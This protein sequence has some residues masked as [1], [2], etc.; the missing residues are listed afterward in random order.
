MAGLLL[1]LLPAVFANDATAVDAS[2]ASTAGIRRLQREAARWSGTSLPSP[3][4]LVRLCGT[5]M[6]C[7]A[8]TLAGFLGHGARLAYRRHPDTDTIRMVRSLPSI[9]HVERPAEG[10]LRV[11]F[12]RFGRAAL[13]E[14]ETVLAASRSPV[15]ILEMDLR[16]HHGGKLRDMMRLASRFTGP[17]H[18]ALALH[19]PDGRVRW[20]DLPPPPRGTSPVIPGLRIIVNHGTASSAEIFAALLRRYGRA[21]ILGNGR[22]RGKNWLLRSIAVTNDVVLL[23]PAEHV[24]VPGETLAGGLRPDGPFLASNGHRTEKTGGGR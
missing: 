21:R 22:T 8:R 19:Y 4:S 13:R 12:M 17:V 3:A 1:C 24:H 14:L 2:P 9:V 11:H 18:R 5:S 7:A 20:L 15:R 16:D 10:V 6:L 23:V